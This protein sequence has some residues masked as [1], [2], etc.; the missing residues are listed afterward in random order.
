VPD[1]GAGALCRSVIDAGGGGLA[2][3]VEH[4]EGA[5]HSGDGVAVAKGTAGW[6]A[7]DAVGE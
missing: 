2:L 3:A 5:E 6:T 1:L 4:D 7:V